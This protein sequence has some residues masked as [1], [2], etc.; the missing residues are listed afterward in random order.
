MSL[1]EDIGQLILARAVTVPGDTWD[2]IKQASRLCTTGYAQN[3]IDIAQGVKDGD[4]PL[5]ERKMNAINAEL[6]L[7]MGI[8][9]TQEIT[10]NEVQKFFNDVIGILKTAINS[11]LPIPIL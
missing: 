6:L 3:L 10:L 2:K 7:A 5:E 4:I 1:T 8:A 11:K 9:N